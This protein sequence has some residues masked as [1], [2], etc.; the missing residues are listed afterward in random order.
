MRLDIRVYVISTRPYAS[1]LLCHCAVFVVFKSPVKTKN[2]KSCRFSGIYLNC[3][4]FS[5]ARGNSVFID[6]AVF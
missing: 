6:M 3:N 2:N 1:C 5:L 4:I